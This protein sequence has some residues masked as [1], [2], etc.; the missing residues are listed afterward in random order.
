MDDKHGVPLAKPFSPEELL[1]R[2]RSVLDTASP[3]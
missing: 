2:V 1:K 3:D